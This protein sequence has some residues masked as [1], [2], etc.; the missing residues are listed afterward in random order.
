M[1]WAQGFAF[2]RGGLCTSYYG[3]QS[4]CTEVLVDQE[5]WDPPFPRIAPPARPRSVIKR[6]QVY[7]S[8]AKHKG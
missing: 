2:S 3:P 5:L 6:A 7:S 8:I 4:R 1:L